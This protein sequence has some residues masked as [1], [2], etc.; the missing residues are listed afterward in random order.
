MQ[1]WIASGDEDDPAIDEGLE[2]FDSIY[3]QEIMPE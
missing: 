1:A 3:E 2:T